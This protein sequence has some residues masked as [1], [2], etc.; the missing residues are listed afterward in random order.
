MEEIRLR[1]APSP[2]GS[3]HIGGLRT[4]LFAYVIAKSQNG[5]LILR[6]EDTDQA[7]EVEGA[8]NHLI[9]I[10]NWSNI[11]FDEGPHQEGNFEPYIQSQR[12]DIYKKYADILLKSD[13]AYRCFCSS[14]RLAEMRKKQQENKKA[15]RYDGYCRN[16]SEKEIE[17]KLAN[18]ESFVI[19]Q[20]MP[21]E[22][23]IKVHDELRGDI[24]FKASDLDDQV[25]I[26]SDQMPTYQ[27][28]SVVDDH[29]MKISH[30]TRGEEWIPSFP[31]NVL[32]YQAFD[33]EIPKFIHLPLILNKE[34]GKL[35]KRQNDVA[36]EDYREQGYLAT[37]LLNFSILLGW[38]PKDDNEIMSLEEIIKVFKIKDMQISP[39][40]FDREKLDYFNAHYLRQLS[41]DSLLEKSKKYLKDYHLKNE[42]YLQKILLLEQ[43][44]IKKLDELPE[45]IDF[46][47]QDKL[48][49]EPELLIWK[50][51]T[52]EET[53]ENLKEMYNFL[54][55]I[56]ENKWE[57]K[58]LEETIINYL[59]E[60][61]K[62]IGNY[63]WPLRVA[64]TGEKNSPG[65]FEVASILKKETS[66]E[67]IESAI[68]LI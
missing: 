64:L 51:S 10:L 47:F 2:T 18:N 8:K 36:V 7:R 44:R 56:E 27:F 35:S 54:N 28:A 39:A 66:L 53:K 13:Q 43:S 62:K 55:D 59:K 4:A 34:G 20:K 25:L 1:F 24:N 48:N 30:V 67:R 14:E 22:G 60:N 41:A 63:L 65:P 52:N 37:A 17:E 5:K 12:K 26:K 29:L 61:D 46:F 57:E 19:R 11:F 42:D 49:Y 3:L 21:L 45:L 23:D 58:Y 38:H 40:V 50:K 15:P 31:K 32:L 68:K 16:L 9:E 6:I 33:W